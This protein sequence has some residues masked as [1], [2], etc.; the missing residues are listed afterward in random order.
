MGLINCIIIFFIFL[1]ELFTVSF[2]A[3]GNSEKLSREGLD[4]YYHFI[5]EIQEKINLFFP[6]KYLD[7]NNYNAE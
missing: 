4:N 5:G 6:N 3:K 7:K 2:L 1:A